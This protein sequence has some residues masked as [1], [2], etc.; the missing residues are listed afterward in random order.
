MKEKELFKILGKMITHSDEFG[1]NHND[2][3][4]MRDIYDELEIK[5]KLI[6]LK[7]IGELKNE[8]NKA[9]NESS[10][11]AFIDGYDRNGCFEQNGIKQGLE[12]AIEII[13]SH[14]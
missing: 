9:D 12:L 3:K 7:I 8:V 1:N 14:I 13:N 10:S 6:K 4:E 2:R 5:I 11:S